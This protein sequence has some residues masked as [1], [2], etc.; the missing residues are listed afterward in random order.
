MATEIWRDFDPNLD[1]PDGLKNA[2]EITNRDGVADPDADLNIQFDTAYDEDSE[3]D[4]DFI[5]EELGV[6][7]SFKIVSQTVRTGMNGSHVVDVVI[8]VED[9]DGAVNYDVRVTKT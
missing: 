7:N 9:V 8:E 2:R 6:P 3:L 4:E 1:I 5:G